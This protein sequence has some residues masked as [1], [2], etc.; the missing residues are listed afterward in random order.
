MREYSQAT[1]LHMILLPKDADGCTRYEDIT[2]SGSVDPKQE[3]IFLKAKGALYL[4]DYDT[5][6]SDRLL[7]LFLG[8]VGAFLG[9]WF[10]TWLK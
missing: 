2:S 10:A 5:R 7:A 3:K 1:S 9:A 6:R 4:E 8:V